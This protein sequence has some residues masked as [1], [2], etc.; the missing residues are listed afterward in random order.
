MGSSAKTQS[1]V[2]KKSVVETYRRQTHRILGEAKS[3]LTQKLSHK[4]APL[5]T[6]K[7][8]MKTELRLTYGILSENYFTRDLHI[9]CENIFLSDPKNISDIWVTYDAWN[10][11]PKLGHLWPRNEQWKLI[12]DRH[13]EYSAKTKSL[14]TRKLSPKIASL[15]T[16]KSSV[17]TKLRVTHEILNQN[18]VTIDL[19]ISSGN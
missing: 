19:E 15:L 2:T 8:S 14:L 18:S 6:Q 12:D 9:V 3:L 4:T 1:I 17:K 13:M 11:Q 5:M 10:P 16:Q 7:W